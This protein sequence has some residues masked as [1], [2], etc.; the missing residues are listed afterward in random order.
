MIEQI[1]KTKGFIEPHE[2]ELFREVDIISQT[3]PVKIYNKGEWARN[4]VI[5]KIGT[6]PLD[7]ILL[8]REMVNNGLSYARGEY[9]IYDGKGGLKVDET[10]I[11]V[12]KIISSLGEKKGLTVVVNDGY[13]RQGDE[14]K[15]E[16]MGGID[17]I[18]LTKRMSHFED[19]NAEIIS[20]YATITVYQA[21]KI[22]AQKVIIVPKSEYYKIIN[23]SSKIAKAYPT[24]LAGKTVM[25][26]VLKAIPSLIGGYIDNSDYETVEKVADRQNVDMEKD[27]INLTSDTKKE[28]KKI[29]NIEKYLKKLNVKE[30]DKLTEEQAKDIIKQYKID[31]FDSIKMLNKIKENLDELDLDKVNKAISKI[32]KMVSH[33]LNSDKKKQL[34]DYGKHLK[35]VYDELSKNRGK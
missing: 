21:G 6:R 33:E 17:T 30:I 26:R 29:G 15:I 24:M 19:D 10:P 7:F 31:T 25:K 28:L 35:G 9:Y 18:V 32:K 23:N 13:L 5:D 12:R 14:A 20:P 34:I 2:T 8:V 11:G 4:T 3:L 27:N 1:N 16:V 22:I